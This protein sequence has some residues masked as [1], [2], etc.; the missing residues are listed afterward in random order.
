MGHEVHPEDLGIC[1]A[2]SK[3]WQ[4]VEAAEDLPVP[5]VVEPRVVSA[6]LLLWRWGQVVQRSLLST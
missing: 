1:V 3:V 4:A 5:Q 2:G 6:A